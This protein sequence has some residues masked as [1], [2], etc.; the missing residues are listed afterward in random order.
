MKIPL[1]LTH[2]VPEF[3]IGDLVLVSTLNFNSIKGPKKLQYSYVGPLLIVSLHGT[4]AVQVELSGELENKH[5]IFPVSLIKP[6][7][8]ADI[9]WFPLRNQTP[10]TVPPVE[11]SE[12]KKIK[13]SLRKGDL[14]VKSNE[15][16]LSEIEI[17][18]RK[19][20]AWENH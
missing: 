15:N 17:Q 11:Q 13:K 19:I 7:Q 20:N 16:I 14:G 8:P 5:P 9:K 10:L 18:Y 1:R 3:K 2:K 6:Y 12:D 4:N